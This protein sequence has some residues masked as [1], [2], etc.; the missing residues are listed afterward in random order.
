MCACFVVQLCLAL[1]YPVDCILSSSSVHG[2]LQA[3]VLCGLP[4][5]FPGDFPNSEIE[6]GSPALQVDTLLPESP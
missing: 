5:P 4:F 2:V 1:C 6:S 3:R